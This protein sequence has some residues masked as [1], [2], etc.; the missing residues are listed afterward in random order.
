MTKI[1]D[2]A[3]LFALD[4]V[5]RKKR[6]EKKHFCTDKSMRTREANFRNYIIPLWGECRV[7]RLTTQNIENGIAGLR[8]PFTQK[9]LAG[10]T[11]NRI[12]SVLSDFY[13][14]LMREGIARSNPVREVELC[15]PSPEV[16]R[17][18]LPTVEMAMLFPGVPAEVK[19]HILLPDT[20]DKLKAIWRTQRYICAF[21][22]LKDTGLRPGE[23]LALKW[24]DWDA[25]TRFFPILKAIESGTRGKEK[26]TKTGAT[27]PAIITERT[28]E[29]IE[30]L[31]RKIKPQPEDYIFC[32]C[33]GT[34]YDCHR[35]SWN[36][37]EGV[38][39][40]GLDRPRYTPYWLRH[41]FNT[42]MLEGLPGS[43]VDHLTG[44]NTESMRR[45]YRH[46][47]EEALKRE[48]ERIKDSVNE[49]RLY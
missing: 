35:L 32:N 4:G 29:E 8:S 43:T 14:Y 39:R 31:R 12:L 44:H 47:D 23:L 3:D 41:T 17:N 21:L 10:S 18:A 40:A 20:H 11:I 45:H 6:E 26:G 13:S 48:A 24:R 9:P 5:W 46:A 27:R 38:K 36:F 25:E 19:H 37:R 1:K 49:A 42:R 15:S 7:R 22:I 33:H 30:L 34:P 16:P 28:A 2:Y